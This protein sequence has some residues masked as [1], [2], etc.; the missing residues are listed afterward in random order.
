V[1]KSA[2]F[3]FRNAFTE[4]MSIELKVEKGDYEK[5]VG[6]LRDLITGLVFTKER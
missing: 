1:V 6:W 5:A 2:Y 3:T 4:V